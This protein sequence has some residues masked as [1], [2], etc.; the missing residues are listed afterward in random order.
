[1]GTVHYWLDD[2]DDVSASPSMRFLPNEGGNVTVKVGPLG[3]I[4]EDV[5]TAHRLRVAFERAELLLNPNSYGN[6]DA[7]SAT[8]VVMSHVQVRVNDHGDRDD[9]RLCEGCAEIANE[10]VA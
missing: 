6:C 9:L 1:M 10:R 8:N 3:L 2:N 4:V 7:C 5:D